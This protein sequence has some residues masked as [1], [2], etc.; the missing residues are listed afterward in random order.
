MKKTIYVLSVLMSLWIVP[1]FAADTVVRKL[2]VSPTEAQIGT[3]K[4]KTNLWK[5]QTEDRE[6]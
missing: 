2:T 3:A 5:V 4:S 6:Y 1:S